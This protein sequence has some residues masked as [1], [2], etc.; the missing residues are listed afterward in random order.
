VAEPAGQEA[1]AQVG[2]VNEM[3]TGAG[4]P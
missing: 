3:V 2:I 1:L 4:V